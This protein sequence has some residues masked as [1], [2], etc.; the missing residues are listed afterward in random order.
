MKRKLGGLLR[1]VANWFRSSRV[2]DAAQT[3]RVARLAEVSEAR[4]ASL[5]AIKASDSAANRARLL[6]SYGDRLRGMSDPITTDYLGMRT[7]TRTNMNLDDVLETSQ[8]LVKFSDEAVSVASQNVTKANEALNK[9]RAVA[10]QDAAAVN[11]TAVETA[12]HSLKAA[13]NYAETMAKSKKVLDQKLA[14]LTSAVEKSDLPKVEKIVGEIVEETKHIKQGAELAV[15]KAKEAE[16]A[17]AASGEF[18]TLAEGAASSSQNPINRVMTAGLEGAAEVAEVGS[19]G[20]TLS[21]NVVGTVVSGGA[22]S[23]LGDRIDQGE[24]QLE[25]GAGRLGEL[26]RDHLKENTNQAAKAYAPI[27]TSMKAGNWAGWY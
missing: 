27:E 2:D 24:D 1:G 15:L 26:L 10:T 22:I 14:E 19:K 16:A 20:A 13:Q 3:M 12:Q 6:D 7:V 21:L 8:E 18:M 4:M 17:S 5:E 23:D 9:A 11:Q 25:A